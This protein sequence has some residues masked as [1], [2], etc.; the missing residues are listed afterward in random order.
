MRRRRTRSCSI[1]LRYC[2]K[3][4]IKA[5]AETRREAAPQ[6]RSIPPKFAR[7]V[8]AADGS[9]S[10]KG[11][12]YNLALLR[13]A[14]R[15]SGLMKRA[16]WCSQNEH[17]QR[18]ARISLGMDAHHPWQLAFIDFSRTLTPTAAAYNSFFEHA[19]KIHVPQSYLLFGTFGINSLT[20]E[21]RPRS[22]FHARGPSAAR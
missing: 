17:L 6:P 15:F 19:T 20:L 4:R 16:T 9:R 1:L 5:Q 10:R 22:H 11:R 18:G 3:P 7:E 8:N 14:K 12:F 2:S 21:P 13:C